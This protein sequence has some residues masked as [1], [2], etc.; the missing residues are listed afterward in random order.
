M[1][2][3]VIIT[4]LLLIS[5]A[6]AFCLDVG[7]RHQINLKTNVKLTTPAFQLEFTSGMANP[8][9]A[10]ITNADG[11]EFRADGNHN[12]F[13][14]EKTAIDVAD[15]SQETLDLLFTVKLANTAKCTE[16]FT[17]LFSAGAFAVTRNLEPGTL[18]PDKDLALAVAKDIDARKGV[19]AN[20]DGTNNCIR[21][22]FNGANC[23]TGDLATFRVRYS[24]DPTIDDNDIGEYYYADIRLD[25]ISEL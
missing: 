25:I 21:L 24:A 1:K 4:M 3:A 17:L 11:D 22:H 12:E 5:A 15:I 6:C 8:G 19:V 13:G 14:T 2:K 9:N 23:T 10:V 16:N 18:E 7:E 20:V